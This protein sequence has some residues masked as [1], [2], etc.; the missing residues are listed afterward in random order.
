M[1]SVSIIWST[2]N[3][4]IVYKETAVPKLPLLEN[5]LTFFAGVHGL[6]RMKVSARE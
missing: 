1:P 2:L 3:R 6:Q 4:D 5:A